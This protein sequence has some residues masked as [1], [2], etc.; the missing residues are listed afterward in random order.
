MTKRR[1][2]SKRFAAQRFAAGKWKISP[3]PPPGYGPD[4]L[5]GSLKIYPHVAGSIGVSVIVGGS[6]EV[7]R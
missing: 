6:I 5:R 3:P 7:N 2:L 4:Y 1:Y